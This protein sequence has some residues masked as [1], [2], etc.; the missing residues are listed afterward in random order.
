M[1]PNVFA[2][3]NTQI[4]YGINR[5]T[6]LF[7]KLYESSGCERPFFAVYFEGATLITLVLASCERPFFA[8]YFEDTHERSHLA[9]CCE[10]P[11]FAVYFE[12][13]LLFDVLQ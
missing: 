4:F 3:Q 6:Y 1:F 13:S 5:I 7:Q 2:H 12:G 11:F 8:V 9:V 10:R